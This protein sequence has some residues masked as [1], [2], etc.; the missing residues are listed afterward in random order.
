M[1]RDLRS[2]SAIS[3]PEVTPAAGSRCRAKR[4]GPPGRE[5]SIVLS[6]NAPIATGRWQRTAVRKAELESRL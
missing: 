4:G 2:W 6:F 3:R 5:L 1:L